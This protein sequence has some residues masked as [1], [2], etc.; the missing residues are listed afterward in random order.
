MKVI[1]MTTSK[2]GAAKTTNTVET[3]AA[4]K[5]LGKKVL[6][7][8]IDQTTGLTKYVGAYYEPDERENLGIKTIYDVLTGDCSVDD[9]I[10]DVEC[11]DLISGDERLANPQ[12]TFNKEDDQYLL[13]DICEMLEENGYDYIFIDH[14]PQKDLLQKMSYIASDYF[15]ITTLMAENDRQ[16]AKNAVAEISQLQK[17]R[18]KL[19][20]GDVYG[21]I[22]SRV[23]KVS[24]SDLAINDMADEAA[25]YKE[26]RS[27]EPRIFTIPDA[28]AIAE[29]QT[30]KVPN[31]MAHKSSN[32]SRA[33]YDL[34]DYILELK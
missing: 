16:Q 22:V 9:A 31:T 30:F 20:T 24:L 2:G 13:K 28:I 26:S 4:L 25:I 33:Y 6:V 29:A 11:F 10:L 7:I 19:V 34:A 3:A 32:V 12:V 1:C 15:F 14:G 17:S 5:I 27:V 18:N 8:D 21:F 23:K